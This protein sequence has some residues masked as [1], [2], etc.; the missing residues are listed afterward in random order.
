MATG[1]GGGFTGSGYVSGLSAT[2]AALTLVLNAA[3]TSEQTL[4]LRYA[5]ESK[6]PA[7]VKIQSGIGQVVEI[8]LPPTGS[9]WN[10]QTVKVRVPLAAGQNSISIRGSG[11]R[12]NL[13][14]IETN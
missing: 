6:E 10:W 3:T 7:L 12:F 4:S 9:W 1:E 14:R 8:S 13:D 2:N 11:G 5:S